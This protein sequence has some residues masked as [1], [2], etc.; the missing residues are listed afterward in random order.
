[1][2]EK[3][4]FLWLY[5]VTNRNILQLRVH[6]YFTGIEIMSHSVNDS[7]FLSMNVMEAL[8]G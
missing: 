8:N 6:I 3:K 7:T 5:T 1:M 4:D 2:V